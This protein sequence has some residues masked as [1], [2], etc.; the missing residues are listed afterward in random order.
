M[1][2]PFRA[3]GATATLSA[4]TTSSSAAILADA[5]SVRVVNLGTVATHLAFGGSA[6]AATTAD[7]VLGPNESAT[8]FKGAAAYVAARTATGTA[9][10]YVTPGEASR[11]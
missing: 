4:T 6:V 8:L 1:G 11:G 9:T 10:V 5:T 2:Q 3:N 7:L